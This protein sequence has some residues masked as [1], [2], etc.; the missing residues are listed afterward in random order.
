MAVAAVP[1]VKKIGETIVPKTSDLARD[2]QTQQSS[3]P[4][5]SR[6]AQPDLNC[7]VSAYEEPPFGVNPVQPAAHILDPGKLS[8][9]IAAHTFPEYNEASS[10]SLAARAVDRYW[11]RAWRRARARQVKAGI[12]P[13]A[14]IQ[15]G[16]AR[17]GG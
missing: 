12:L 7:A 8:R 16:V 1:S 5:V 13:R 15:T 4:R 9:A 14:A 11:E 17:A 3:E 6:C 2:W 10:G